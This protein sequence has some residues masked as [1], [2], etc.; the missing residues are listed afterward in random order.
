VLVCCAHWRG[1]PERPRFD[2]PLISGANQMAASIGNT[3]FRDWMNQLCQPR[4]N[5][6]EWPS[7][8]VWMLETEFLRQR[9]VDRTYTGQNVFINRDD[10]DPLKATVPEK[11]A[12]YGLYH[13]C[14]K[15]SARCLKIGEDLFWLL[16]YEWPNQGNY[17]MRRA[18]LVGLTREGGLVVF[19]CKLDRNPYAP[20]AAV[21]EGLDY[22]S[23]L[24]GE[25]NFDRLAAGFWEWREKLEQD[26]PPGFEQCEPDPASRQSVILL[27]PQSY[28]NLYTQSGR[29]QGWQ[30]LAAISWQ[31]CPRLGIGFA[32]SDF[33]TPTAQWVDPKSFS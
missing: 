8:M 10:H 18:D 14:R 26:V 7:A 23:C 17:R 20:L 30:N 29:G 11:R 33:E 6:A 25:R 31:T 22:L 12:V 3:T 15:K 9:T 27:A 5:Q 16:G 21:L 19:E 4:G 2:A 28:Y 24:T 13:L 1:P 32:L